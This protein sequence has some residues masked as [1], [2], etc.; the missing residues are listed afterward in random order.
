MDDLKGRERARRLGVSVTGMLGELIA[1][2][3]FGF[4]AAYSRRSP[5]EELDLL[6]QAGMRLTDELRSRVLR[7]L[8]SNE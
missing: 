7:E 1:L 2:H 4:A 6:S 3:S 5:E 8:K